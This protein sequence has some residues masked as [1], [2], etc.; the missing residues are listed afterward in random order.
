[1]CVYTHTHRQTDREIFIIAVVWFDDCA[2]LIVCVFI[3]I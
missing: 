1:M 3:I 2:V